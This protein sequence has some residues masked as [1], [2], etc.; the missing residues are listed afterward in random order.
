MWSRVVEVMLACWLLVS[1]FVFDVAGEERALRANAWIGAAV[2]MTLALA[3]MARRFRHAH[4]GILV[5]ALWLAAHTFLA[6]EV[7]PPG[8]AYQNQLVVALLLAMI[9][10]LP[11]RTQEPPEGWVAFY[12]RRGRRIDPYRIEEREHGTDAPHH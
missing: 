11:S 8:P 7:T 3:S 4:L 2:V 6:P 9:A 12:V 10:V 1:P 5:V